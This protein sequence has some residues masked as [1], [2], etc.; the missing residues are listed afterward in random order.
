MPSRSRLPRSCG[1]QERALS[2][3]ARLFG[4]P[5][6]VSVSAPGRVNLIGEHTDYNGGLVLPMALP[7][8]TRVQL[9]RRDDRRVRCVTATPP[10]VAAPVTYEIGAESRAGRWTDYVQAVTHVLADSGYQPPGLDVLVDSTIPMGS[11]LSSSAAL[12]VAML[13]GLRA[14]MGLPFDDLTLAKLAHRGETEFVQSPVG[15]MDPV[16]CSVGDTG[17]ALLLD[18]RTL[19][20]ERVA[21]PTAL[22]LA[23]IDSGLSHHHAS[24][25]YRTRRAECEAAARLLNVRYLTDIGEAELSR[26]APLPSPLDRRARHV[27]TENARVTAT[28]AALRAEALATVGT[29]FYASHDSMRDDFEVSLPDIDRIVALAHSHDAVL[30]ARL[31]GGGFGGSVLLLCRAGRAGDVAHEIVRAHASRHGARVLIPHDAEERHE[32]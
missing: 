31:T 24:G 17:A 26:C 27:I 28:V 15:I 19:E 11:G 6:D 30:G 4:R 1:R 32:T 13:R 21:M 5:A 8:S 29:L 23:V 25:G 7:L 18:T 22:E 2:D 12:L 10:L 16:A 3:F 14:L 20:H 9:A